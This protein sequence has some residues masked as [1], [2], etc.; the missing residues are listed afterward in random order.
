MI[1]STPLLSLTA[2]SHRT[3]PEKDVDSYPTISILDLFRNSRF[4]SEYPVLLLTVDIDH[5]ASMYLICARRKRE[6]WSGRSLFKFISYVVISLSS[7]NSLHTQA[8]SNLVRS[9]VPSLAR[10]SPA[11]SASFESLQV[12]LKS[13]SSPS[14]SS[15]SH[16][17]L[18]RYTQLRSQETSRISSKAIAMG[19][20]AGIGVLIGLL[21][22]VR[23]LSAREGDET[24]PLRVA[25]AVSG[26]LWL[27]GTVGELFLFDEISL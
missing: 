18:L 4:I 9:T 8:D 24:W 15:D 1:V 20:A 12:S 13:P 14:E 26:A 10:L 21:P 6:F 16:N 11:V 19:Y 2:V 7:F 17:L 27:I 25:I 23:W 3:E 22:I 5:L